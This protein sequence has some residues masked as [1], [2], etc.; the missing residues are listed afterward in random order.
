M[1]RNLLFFPSSADTGVNVPP[2]FLET[3][4]ITGVRVGGGSVDLLVTRH[5]QDVG[6]TVLRRA[7]DIEVV[8][9]KH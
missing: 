2:S 6:V 8:V 1:A 4:R 9:L 7:G 5:E 3:V